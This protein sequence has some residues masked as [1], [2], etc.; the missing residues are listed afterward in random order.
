MGGTITSGVDFSTRRARVSGRKHESTP[1]G[2]SVVLH[3]GPF[4]NA[5]LLEE[6]ARLDVTVEVFVTFAVLYFLADRVLADRDA[7][8][9]VRD[10]PPPAHVRR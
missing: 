2:P 4:L 3:P 9:I 7:Q 8:R 10:I 6:A 1:E 5:T